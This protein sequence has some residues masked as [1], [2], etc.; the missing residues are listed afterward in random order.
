M[1]LKL[2]TISNFKIEAVYMKFKTL[3]KTDTKFPLIEAPQ[4]ILGPV[5]M[6]AL[7]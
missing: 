3:N 6:M 1:S 7:K 4:F 2:V 5:F